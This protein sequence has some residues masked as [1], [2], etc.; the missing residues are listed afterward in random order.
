MRANDDDTGTWRPQGDVV[1]PRLKLLHSV[2]PVV[3]VE[4]EEV[5]RPLRQEALVRGIVLLLA[6]KVPDAKVERL[7]AETGSVPPLAHLHSH[8]RLVAA[9]FALEAL[10]QCRLPPV[11]QPHQH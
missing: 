6:S 3:Q 1:Q 5:E 7:A 8:C 9:L 11:G 4:E 2:V 10:D